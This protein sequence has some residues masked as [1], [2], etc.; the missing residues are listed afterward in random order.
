M[1]LFPSEGY[2]GWGIGANSKGT[3]W[4]VNP[5]A[6]FL[7]GCTEHQILGRSIDDVIHLTNEKTFFPPEVRENMYLMG[8]G[9]WSEGTL[10]S[11]DGRRIPVEKRAAPIMVSEIFLGLIW[12]FRD[13][14]ARQPIEE[15]P[16]EPQ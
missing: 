3:I 9:L 13:L 1:A 10:L 6:E 4:F 2:S 7:L 8:E 15:G 14:S 12:I 16:V 11:L 5:K